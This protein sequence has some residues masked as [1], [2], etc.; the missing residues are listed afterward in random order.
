MSNVSVRSINANFKRLVNIFQRETDVDYKAVPDKEIQKCYEGAKSTEVV[1]NDNG[2]IT[3]PTTDKSKDYLKVKLIYM[4]PE[5][6]G[7]AEIIATDNSI[8]FTYGSMSSNYK[9]LYEAITRFN[10]IAEW[11]ALPEE[12]R[13]EA[14]EQYKEAKPLLKQEF[15]DEPD[16]PISIV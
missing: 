9:N 10:R 2:V 16:R 12:T 7:D 6:K 14:I 15:A 11:K 4:P 3:S 13:K 1:V 8:Q 5:E